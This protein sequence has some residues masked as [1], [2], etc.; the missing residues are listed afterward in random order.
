MTL[1]KEIS[2]FL[3]L[4]E[5]IWP[6]EFSL[7]SELCLIGRS[8]SCQIIVPWRTASRVHAKIERHDLHYVLCDT[9]SANGTF[10]NSKRI[11]QPRLL[12]HRDVI[13]LG[14]PVPMLRFIDPYTTVE[15]GERLFYD[16]SRT[17]FIVGL[18]PL[19]LSRPQRLLLLHLYRNAGEI[20][21]FASCIEA[22]FGIEHAPNNPIP[23]LEALVWAINDQLLSVAPVGQCDIV[24]SAVGYQLRS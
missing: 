7:A 15:L 1:Q 11:Y 2:R 9:G 16:E 6:P 10:V 14:A 4:R 3:A 12:R 18:Q 22:V 5:D 21:T 24:A 13:G 17:T 23:E 20:C 19:I 8:P